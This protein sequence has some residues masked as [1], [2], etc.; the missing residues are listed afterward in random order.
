MN[1]MC[2]H[3]SGARFNIG[4]TE[5]VCEAVDSSGNT[6]ECQFN[7]TIKGKATICLE[8]HD[9]LV[10][11]FYIFI[12]EALLYSVSVRLRGGKRLLLK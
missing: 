11:T 1:V 8:A 9:V 10:E 6:G 4:H 5:V 3:V 2:S 12:M 7:V